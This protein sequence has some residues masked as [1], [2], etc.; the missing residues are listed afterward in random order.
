MT[1]YKEPK[2]IVIYEMNDYEPAIH[3]HDTLVSAIKD[4]N[5]N[6]EGR[7]EGKC[8]AVVLRYEE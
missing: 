8:I 4:W 1:P 2:Y 6:K 3:E 7:S 5:E